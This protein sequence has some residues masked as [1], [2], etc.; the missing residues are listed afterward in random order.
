MPDPGHI[1]FKAGID[2]R[3]VELEVAVFLR[4]R[5]Q[6][7]R[8]DRDIAPLEALADIPDCLLPRGRG[9]EVTELAALPAE[10]LATD[11]LEPTSLGIMTIQARKVELS[12]LD[13]GQRPST[14]ISFPCARAGHVD[15]HLLTIGQ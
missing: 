6:L 8:P 9:G 3:E 5:R 7:V 14:L 13:I 11:P 4:I 2:R 12:N 1:E 15:V 10:P